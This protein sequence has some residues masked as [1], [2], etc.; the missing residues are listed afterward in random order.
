MSKVEVVQ[1]HM[2]PLCFLPSGKLVAYRFG[3]VFI[4]ENDRVEK[5]IKIFSSIKETI[6]GRCQWISRLLRLGIRATEVIDENNILISVS[7]TIFELNLKDGILSSGYYCGKGIRP[8]M[9]AQVSDV[10]SVKK[11][12][13]FGEYLSNPDKHEVDIYRRTGV[14]KWSVVHTFKQGEINHIHAIIPDKYRDCLWVFTGDFDESAAIWK[15]TDD[16]NNVERILCAKQAYRGCVAFAIEEG[17]LYATDA[18]F[19]SNSIFL[20]NPFT[21][22]LKEIAPIN[23]SC[24]YGCKWRDNYVFSTTVEGDGRNTSRMEFYFGRKRGA[25]IKNDYV[26]LYIGN[27]INGFKEIYKARKDCLPYYTFQFGVFKFPSGN[28]MG[29]ELYF[30]PIA[31]VGTDLKLMK[32]KWDL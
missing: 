5:T 4:L 23:G 14:D 19:A 1:R 17:L 12:I 9:F 7:N 21:Y 16:F 10:S 11:G 32:V 26:Y 18:P 15:V 2:Q 25:G 3:K 22:D 28:N 8:L 29:R 31:V 27:P 20:M 6:L 13:Y 30:Q 24:I